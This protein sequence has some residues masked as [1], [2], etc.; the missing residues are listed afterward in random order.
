MDNTSD[1]SRSSRKRSASDTPS[2]P[3]TITPSSTTPQILTR[4]Y[5]RKRNIALPIW[6]PD[7]AL[8]P[9]SFPTP[10]PAPTNPITTSPN[11]PAR[12]N[13]Y[14]SLLRHPNLFFQFAIRLPLPSLIA[15]YAIDKEFH[16]RLNKFSVGLIH[17]YARYHAPVSSHIFAWILYPELLISDPMLRPM[18]GRVWLARDVPGL[19][20]V[21]MVLW[22]EWIVRGILS[23][24]GVAGHRVPAR[25]F[26][27][28]CK[29]WVVMEMRTTKMREAFLRDTE[30]WSDEDV[31]LVQMLLVKLDMRFADAT[32]GNGAMGLSHM[33]LTQRSLSTLYYVLVGKVKLDY[34]GTTD[35]V[36]R[37]YLT[38][39]LDLEEY[40]WLDDEAENGVPEEWWGIQMREGWHPDGLKMESAVDMVIAEGVRRGLNVQQYLLD[41][42]LYGYLDEDGKNGKVVRRWRGN[43]RIVEEDGLPGKEERNA[44]IKSLDARFGFGAAH[45]EAMDTSV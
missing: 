13:I 23:A 44:A 7:L 21:G 37:T 27:A 5:H 33:L 20:W 15:L 4:N 1:L 10:A 16:Y 12:F 22:R 17:D 42:V 26:G 19:R 9:S 8:T 3:P 45:G 31:L 35:M 40:S 41:F 2:T 34:D 38:G 25:M 28:L 18:D 39:E 43:K 14:K 11:V 6:G 29:F 36:V 30:I 32:L 24:L